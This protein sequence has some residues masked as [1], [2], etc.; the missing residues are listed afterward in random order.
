MYIEFNPET[1][2]LECINED[3]TTILKILR[4]FLENWI[5]IRNIGINNNYRIEFRFKLITRLHLIITQ[6]KEGVIINIHE[7]VVRH[8]GEFTERCRNI[9]KEI[10]RI[11]TECNK[12]RREDIEN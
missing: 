11:I 1:N 8:Q 5:V 9:M 2:S 7:D 12:K 6:T 4:E 10:K 3:I